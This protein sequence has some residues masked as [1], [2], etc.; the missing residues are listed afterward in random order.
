[1]GVGKALRD[2]GTDTGAPSTD[3][4]MPTT[5]KRIVS[6]HVIYAEFRRGEFEEGQ[7]PPSSVNSSRQFISLIFILLVDKSMVLTIDINENT[8]WNGI[9][10]FPP[11]NAG[12]RLCMRT[13]HL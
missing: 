12:R 3:E 10:P 8:C 11:D 7:S 6:K 9:A 13:C 4:T 2:K 1:M 5:A